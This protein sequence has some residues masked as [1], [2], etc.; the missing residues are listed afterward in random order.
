V[1]EWVPRIWLRPGSLTGTVRPELEPG[2]L[3]G[4]SGPGTPKGST[5]LS[6]SHGD[7]KVVTGSWFAV[8]LVG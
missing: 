4:P 6:V 1:V 5:P 2:A 8:R 3:G 7:H